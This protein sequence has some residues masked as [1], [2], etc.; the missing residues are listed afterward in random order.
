MKMP[1]IVQRTIVY[2][3]LS[4][5]LLSICLLVLAVPSQAA[6]DV[7]ATRYE[8]AVETRMVSEEHV[9]DDYVVSGEASPGV[10][11]RRERDYHDLSGHFSFFFTPIL[12]DP[13]MPIALRRF[14]ARVSAL[15]VSGIIE[16]EHS[17]DYAFVNPAIN[18]RTSS[19]DDEQFRQ[20][21]VDGL[22]YLTDQ[23]GLR[24]HALSA[25]DEQ[26]SFETSP[27][28]ETQS[29]NDTNEI[30]RDYGVGVRH[31]LSDNLALTID[32]AYHDG[33]LRSLEKTWQDNP[34]I[35]S[36]TRRI[37]DTTGHAFSL[38]GEY[39]WQQRLGVQLAYEYFSYDSDSD[40]QIVHLENFG[41]ENL[42]FGD[43]GTQQAITPIA[44]LYLGERFMVQ[45]GGG[46]T[47]TTLTRT[48]D[49]ATDVEYTWNWWQ[50][51]GGVSY[52]FTRHLGV[53]A[54]YQYRWRDGEV[55]MRSDGKSRSIFQVE[56]D[57]QEIQ[58][59]VTG[60]F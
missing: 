4:L 56:S 41:G 29:R 27:A 37:T 34:L 22:F 3:L 12:D 1:A 30:R 2:R 10:H 28:V 24:L 25:K 39:V 14:Y 57:V 9:Q 51:H 11:A 59:G 45:C 44:R 60:R 50:A 58:V 53:Q 26:V 55:K 21:G 13:A 15:H 23:T 43:D 6:E 47:W 54:N 48:Y 35:F 18:Y 5:F 19:E 8:I 33:E 16:P 31:Y 49:N 46:M 17:T 52:Y 38:S 20:A 36:E 40:V 42:T 7:D 32:Y